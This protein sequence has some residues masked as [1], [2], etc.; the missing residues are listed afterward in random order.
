M[1]IESHEHRATNYRNIARMTS[2]TVG[3]FAGVLLL[4]LNASAMAQDVPALQELGKHIFFDRIS[5]PPRQWCSTCHEAENGWTGG[6]AGINKK[7]CGYTGRQ[8]HTVGGR[9]PPSNA[10]PSFSPPFGTRTATNPNIPDPVD[11]C[12]EGSAFL[13]FGGVFWD[14]RAEG[15]ATPLVALPNVTG[16][17]ATPHV[18]VEIFDTAAQKEA[19]GGLIG[20]VADQALGPFPN[21]VEQ[22]LPDGDDGGFPG[23]GAVCGHVKLAK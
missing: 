6:V 23:A 5:N 20:P 7:G 10:Y 17:G 19:Y 4:L 3:V 8:P 2:A 12:S 21:D 1:R 13:C 15:N 18:G 22:N 11:S 14:G 16:A 9:R